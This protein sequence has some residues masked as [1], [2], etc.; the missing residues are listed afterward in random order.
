M[1]SEIVRRLQERLAEREQRGVEEY[2]VTID[3]AEGYDW[4]GEAI[5]EL[6]DACVYLER[7]RKERGE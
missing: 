4:I 6:L 2:G 1:S 3:D 5:D 7:A